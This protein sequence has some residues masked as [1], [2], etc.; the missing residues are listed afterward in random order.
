MM[1]VLGNHERHLPEQLVE[2]F[3]TGGE[4]VESVFYGLVIP[5]PY[6]RHPST[7]VK[8]RVDDGEPSR[9]I[10]RSAERDGAYCQVNH[11]MEQFVECATRIESHRRHYSYSHLDVDVFGGESE[12]D[13]FFSDSDDILVSL[14]LE[15]AIEHTSLIGA[16][17][18]S[19]RIIVNQSDDD[20]P[21][22]RWL[23]PAEVRCVRD[24][25][26][27]VP[28]RNVCPFCEAGPIVCVHC[29]FV[30][31]TCD[32]CGETIVVDERE[33]GGDGDP[34]YFERRPEKIPLIIDGARWDGSDFIQ[35][36]WG[37]PCFV[38]RR[39]VDFLL[40][41]DA[42]PF[43]AKPVRVDIRGCSAEQ[44]EGL[45]RGRGMGS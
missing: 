5:F 9:W 7:A 19:V 12:T 35:G 16:R 27:F 6:D 8:S 33:H 18:D 2:Y 40:S 23:R 30:N 21:C 13:F 32:A 11:G 26:S 17:F 25:V 44:L 36:M 14:E 22:F 38:T 15:A 43:I 28:Q 41:I 29:G 3:D 10:A 37:P 20:S 4:F 31:R 45:E 34:R 1:P 42:K 39:V 24:F